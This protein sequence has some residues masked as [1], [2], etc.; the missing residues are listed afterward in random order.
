MELG[1]LI[2]SLSI[3]LMAWLCAGALP[4]GAE[5]P[6]APAQ[7]SPGI[8]ALMVDVARVT[9]QSYADLDAVQADIDRRFATIDRWFSLAALATP[10]GNALAMNTIDA[11]RASIARRQVLQDALMARL[12]QLYTAADLT[13]TERTE[14]RRGH[15]QGAILMKQ[16][17]TEMDKATL[18]Y[19]SAMRDIVL[20]V[21]AE[22][23]AGRLKINGSDV[24]FTS[25]AQ[26]KFNA[27]VDRLQ[28]TESRVKMLD[29]Q[30]RDDSADARETV[31]AGTIDH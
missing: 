1:S 10:A 28:S 30:I 25:A 6:G 14:V 15:Q 29:D 2:R 19:N 11:A 7:L 9:R 16:R 12:D 24:A 22:R 21:E 5:T 17:Q 26:P 3:A 20:F 23:A 27:L 8:R 31:R 4:V 13:P 18:D